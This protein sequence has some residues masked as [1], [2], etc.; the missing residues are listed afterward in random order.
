MS[1]ASYRAAPPRVG[2][3]QPYV[4]A[5]VKPNRSPTAVG[6]SLAVRLKINI[7]GTPMAIFHTAAAAARTPCEDEGGSDRREVGHLVAEQLT[8]MNHEKHAVTEHWTIMKPGAVT[9]GHGVP[10]MLD[11]AGLSLRSN[12]R[13][14]TCCKEEA[15]ESMP[16][17]SPGWARHQR[18]RWVHAAVGH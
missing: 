17:D 10:R 6:S 4:S 1:P 13:N 16:H 5:E 12:V 14:F 8:A 7:S 11:R 3:D 18:V 15:S 2:S 9:T